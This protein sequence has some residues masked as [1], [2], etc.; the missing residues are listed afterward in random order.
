MDKTPCKDE[1]LTPAKRLRTNIEM[2]IHGTVPKNQME[3]F[4][5]E[6]KSTEDILEL[7][8]TEKDK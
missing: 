6:N 4:K 8:T 2:F 1:T 3:K 7:L 5:K